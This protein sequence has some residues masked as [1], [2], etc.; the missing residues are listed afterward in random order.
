MTIDI[1]ILSL[2]MVYWIR[3]KCSGT[4]IEPQQH[5]PP[6]IDTQSMY[7][8]ERDTILAFACKMTKTPMYLQYKHTFLSL[9]VYHRSQLPS[10][11]KYKRLSE[12]MKGFD[13]NTKAEGAFQISEYPLDSQKVGGPLVEQDIGSTFL[14]CR[15]EPIACL[16]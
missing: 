9:I 7:V 6:M 14:M 5:H 2:S 16:H 1:N 3:S 4:Q 11:H 13:K 15:S 8:L 12:V 10:P